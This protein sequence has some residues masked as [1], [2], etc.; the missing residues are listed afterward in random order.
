MNSPIPPQK[1]YTYSTIPFEYRN[2]ETWPLAQTPSAAQVKDRFPSLSD[3][4][5]ELKSKEIGIRFDRLSR[6]IRIYLATGSLKKG[7]LEACCCREVFYTQLNRCLLPDPLTG[8]GILGWAGL[9]SGL[10]VKGYSRVSDGAGTAGQ[11]QKWIRQSTDW[12]ELLHRMILKGNGGEGMATRKPTVRHVASNFIRAFSLFHKDIGTAKIPLGVYPH[13]GKGNARRAIERYI[14]NFVAITPEA[15]G[16]W[17]GEDIA[18]KQHLGTGKQSFNLVTTPFDVMGSDAH[19]LD[20]L[21]VIIIQGPSGPQRIPVSRIQIVVNICQSKRA[22]SGYSVCLRPQIEAAHVEEAYSR[23]RTPWQPMTLT[24][25]G[26]RY[27]EGAGFPCGSVDGIDEVNPASIRLDNAAQHYAKGIRTRLRKSLGC[28]VAW[29]GVGHWW[30][31]AITERLFGTLARYG[32][33]RLPS[34]TGSG[35]KDPHRAANPALEAVGR[36]IEWEELLQIIDV[37]LANYN[38]RPHKSLGGVSPLDSLRASLAGRNASW[39]PRITPPHSANSP[40]I[41]VQVEPHHIRGS[42]ENRVAPY[43]EVGEVRYTDQC[44]SSRYDWIGRAVSVHIPVDCRTV[45]VYLDSGEYAGA[46]KCMDRGWALSPHSLQL[47]KTVNALVRK[48]EV[49]VSSGGDP[50]SAYMVHLSK[51]AV[52]AAAQGRAGKVSPDAT[53]LADVQRQT[54][55]PL[56][57]ATVR[58]EAAN[59]PAFGAREKLGITLPAAWD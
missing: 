52:A 58:K 27:H 55:L 22:I 51:K 20:A 3:M 37:L 38:A 43:V 2:C 49:W 48:G 10:R 16:V 25:E 17:F 42:V 36:G 39:F 19:T 32:F 11:F 59:K 53:A 24:V 29:G 30:R 35:H 56:P 34:T 50:I 41:G 18:N 14:D 46:L 12:R 1:P 6:G 7:L 26:L 40:R 15:T 44:I 47:R 5:A 4:Q 8:E 57:A 21:G 13:D 33:Q 54:G 23:G 31:N 28:G 9:I 45:E